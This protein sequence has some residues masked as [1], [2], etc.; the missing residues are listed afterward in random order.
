MALYVVSHS[1]P[2]CYAPTYLEGPEVENWEKY[3]EGL[4]NEAI[5]QA[6]YFA[7]KGNMNIYNDENEWDSTIYQENLSEALI[8]VL[9]SKGYVQTSLPNVNFNWQGDWRDDKKIIIHNMRADIQRYESFLEEAKQ[10]KTD[11]DEDFVG[12]DQ[13]EYYEKKIPELQKDLEDF[14]KNN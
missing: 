1:D 13:L 5:E 2:E 10:E 4:I 8:K 3:C 7:T 12:D 14:L 6:I 11:G 9:E